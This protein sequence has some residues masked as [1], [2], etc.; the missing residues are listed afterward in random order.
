MTDGIERV[1]AFIAAVHVA[2]YIYHRL[3]ILL[4]VSQCMISAA[5]ATENRYQ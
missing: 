3:S 2:D 4:S 5:A 1:V